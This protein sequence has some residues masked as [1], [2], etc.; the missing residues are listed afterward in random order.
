MRH[1]DV[2][3]NNQQAALYIHQNPRTMRLWRRN[4][5]LPHLRITKKSILYRKS[6][7]DRWLDQHRTEIVA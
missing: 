2:V 5:G 6:D 4:L 1:D 3:F 7:L